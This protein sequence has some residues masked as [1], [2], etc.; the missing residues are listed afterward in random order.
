METKIRIDFRVI[1]GYR[2]GLATRAGKV[3]ATT[4]PQRLSGGSDG[5]RHPP[6]GEML[7]VPMRPEEQSCRGKQKA[8][9]WLRVIKANLKTG[10]KDAPSKDLL[11]N[12]LKNIKC[13][14]VGLS[15]ARSAV[16]TKTR[17]TETGDELIIDAGSR[18]E[19]IGGVGFAVRKSVVSHIVEVDIVS[20][21]IATLKLDV[22]KK[23]PASDHPGIRPALR[24]HRRRNRQLLQPTRRS[25]PTAGMSQTRHRRLQR[26]ARPKLF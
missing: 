1:V 13:D 7:K 14:I 21:R 23:T 9:K 8:R 15:E 25:T 10:I 22:G 26:T 2:P 20:S 18:R 16:E 3:L 5:P 12:Q 11:L 4:R 24:L 17:C 19:P 6:N